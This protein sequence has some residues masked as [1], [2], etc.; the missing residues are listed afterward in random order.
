MK[1]LLLSIVLLGSGCRTVS[2]REVS[3]TPPPSVRVG[4]HARTWEVV[5][6]GE[7]LGLVVLFEHARHA[8]GSL[9]VVRNAWHQDLGLIDALGRAY[10]YLPHH[11][12]PAWVGSGTVAAG[13]QRIFGATAEC[14]LLELS[15]PASDPLPGSTIGLAPA[16]HVNEAKPSARPSDAPSSDG[17]LPQS[18]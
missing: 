11:E 6:G 16:S 5:S 1:T 18:R 4:T 8:Q 17:G 7:R 13:A 10:R 14:E 9:Y 15:E 3:S 12:E 2:T